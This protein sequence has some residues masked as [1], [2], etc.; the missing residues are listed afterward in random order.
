VWLSDASE[1][2][3]RAVAGPVE[4]PTGT[5]VTLRADLPE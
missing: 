1:Q 2:P 3:L 5:I 4:V